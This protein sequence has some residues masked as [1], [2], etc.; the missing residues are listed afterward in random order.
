MLA[1]FVDQL[2]QDLPLPS[3]ADTFIFERSADAFES[4]DGY[5]YSTA[6]S[7]RKPT[8]ARMPVLLKE[9]ELARG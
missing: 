5:F 8:Q 6:V 9:H 1:G 4:H 7:I 2:E 3:E